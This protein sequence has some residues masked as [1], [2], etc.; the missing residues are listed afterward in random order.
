MIRALARAGLGLLLLASVVLTLHSGARIA[1]DPLLRPFVDRSLAEVAAVTDRMLARDATSALLADRLSA[2][3]AEEPRNWVAIEAVEGVAAERGLALPADI[4]MQR[5]DAWQADS[6]I[7]A[8]AGACA[9][10]IWDAGTCSLSNALICQA[11]VALTP[12]G[13]IAG[14]SRAGVAAVTGGE[15]DEI[16]LALSVVGLSATALVIATGGSSALVKAGAGIG[17][18][19]RRMNLLTPPLARFITGGLRSGVDLA[20]L[21]AVRSADD[22]AAVVRADA[23]APLADLA[24]D[25]GRI[26]DA[27]GA[28]SALHLLRYVNDGADA[29][30]LANAAEALGPRTIGRIEVLGKARVLRATT[31]VSDTLVQIAVGLGGLLA[32]V[33][34]LLGAAAQGLG[35]RLLRLVLRLV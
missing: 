25:L 13:D 29:R 23:L 5:D 14:L 24:A 16:D 27:T 9:A 30:R 31:R 12:L 32:S 35:L 3:L 34:A 1:E 21:R 4:L 8:N 7:F 15:V 33:T 6:G 28:T 11:P 22:L 2:L 10:C 17:R 19:A 26:S 20:A 18:L